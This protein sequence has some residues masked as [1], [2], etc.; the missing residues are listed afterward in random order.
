MTP[1]NDPP[2]SMGPDE[3][4]ELSDADMDKLGEVKMA[5]AE[6]ASNGGP[7]CRHRS[8]SQTLTLSSFSFPEPL[9]RSKAAVQ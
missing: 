9:S 5:A 4:P 2:A 8:G 7:P 1:D 6:A 3:A